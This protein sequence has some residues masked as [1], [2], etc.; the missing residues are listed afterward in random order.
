MFRCDKTQADVLKGLKNAAL[1]YG[2]GNLLR[3]KCRCCHAIWLPGAASRSNYKYLVIK[4]S[5][6]LGSVS[7]S[8]NSQAS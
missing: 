5:L 7:N 6:A 4:A 1:V 2:L 3:H 8:A